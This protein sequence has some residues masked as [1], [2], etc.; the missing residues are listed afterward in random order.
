MWRA[1]EIKHRFMYL[2]RQTHRE[3]KEEQNQGNFSEEI[4]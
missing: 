3:I 1:P 2:V 4:G